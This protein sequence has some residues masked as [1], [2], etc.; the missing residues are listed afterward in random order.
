[1]GPWTKLALAIVV[2][3]TAT[4]ALRQSNGFTHLAWSLVCVGGYVISFW[5]L[6]QITDQLEIGVIYAVWSAAGTAIVAVLGIALFDEGVSALKVLGLAMI[7]GGVVA[8]NLGGAHGE[9]ASVDPGDAPDEA[10]AA[11]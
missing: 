4:I 11:R 5:L 3:V 7:V 6:A 1:M 10:L 9:S 8:L 2:E